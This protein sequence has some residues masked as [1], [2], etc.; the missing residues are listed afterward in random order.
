M[1][2]P[3][4]AEQ[5]RRLEEK[6]DTLTSTVGAL[7]GSQDRL[8]DQMAADKRLADQFNA[9]LQQTLTR[10]Q[11]E[12]DDERKDRK[13]AVEGERV[14]RKEA[15]DRLSG[16]LSKI[17]FALFTAALALVGSGLLYVVTSK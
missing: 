10:L 2:P 7:R 14:A 4:N 6:L 12:L 17:A 3:T 8:A 16:T 15:D 5:L 11:A 9:F 1:T 13:D